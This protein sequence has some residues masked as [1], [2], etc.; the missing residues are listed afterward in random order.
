[1]TLRPTSATSEEK[2]IGYEF[3]LASK[4]VYD[5][6]KYSKNPGDLEDLVE[7]TDKGYIT[8]SVGPDCSYVI[9]IKDAVVYVVFK[10]TDSARDVR[11]DARMSATSFWSWMTG[12]SKTAMFMDDTI[13]RA[14]SAIGKR[15]NELPRRYTGH[16]LGGAL[17]ITA[18]NRHG[19]D[20][21]ECH[22]FSPYM[23]IEAARNIGRWTK[24]NKIIV[25]AHKDDKFWRTAWSNYESANP[26]MVNKMLIWHDTSGLPLE[27]RFYELPTHQMGNMR[28]YFEND[29]QG[30][31]PRRRTEANDTV[32]FSRSELPRVA[33]REVSDE[34]RQE[35]ILEDP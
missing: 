33:R 17:A 20:I 10:G 12:K 11:D 31:T 13:D 6:N 23:D 27:G 4:R 15:Y 16:S 5:C 1:M 22:V 2:A 18:Y 8:Q 21:D 14:L 3:Y 29:I 25:W 30:V 9:Y 7:M 28:A 35:W 34:T 26:D 32:I 19:R 24:K